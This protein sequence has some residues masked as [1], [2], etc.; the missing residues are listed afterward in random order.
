VVNKGK[1]KSPSRD[2]LSDEPSMISDG[3][4]NEQ[5]KQSRGGGLKTNQ[6]RDSLLIKT[7]EVVKPPGSGGDLNT[8]YQVVGSEGRIEKPAFNPHAEEF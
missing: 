6:S 5:E 4:I 1:M 8:D 3:N 7:D 2:L